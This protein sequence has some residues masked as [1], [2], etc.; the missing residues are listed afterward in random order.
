MFK[1]HFL[2]IIP[3]L[4][5]ES[6]PVCWTIFT[7]AQAPW[8]T[9]SIPGL[10]NAISKVLTA[11]LYFQLSLCLLNYNC[12][13]TK[14]LYVPEVLNI[15]K[16]NTSNFSQNFHPPNQLIKPETSPPPS[17]SLTSIYH[18]KSILPP[19][20]AQ[21]P[22]TTLIQTILISSLEVWKGLNCSSCLQYYLLRANSPY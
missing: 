17:L 19:W 13:S 11:N 9:S 5:C 21:A 6:S 3:G 7:Q 20:N 16:P 12:T 1:T 14:H 18:V 15:F 4:N 8:V 10:Q 2:K 22:T